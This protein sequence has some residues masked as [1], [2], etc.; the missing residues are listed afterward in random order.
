MNNIGFHLQLKKTN[1]ER[2]SKELFEK[3]YASL[4]G[5]PMPQLKEEILGL[6]ENEFGFVMPDCEQQILG[7]KDI[8]EKLKEIA[9]GCFTAHAEQRVLLEYF[10]EH[11][12]S[13][14]FLQ[15]VT[16]LLKNNRTHLELN[17]F[18]CQITQKKK[19]KC[20][21]IFNFKIA[22]R[23]AIYQTKAR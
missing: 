2:F 1:H 20:Q 8:K 18:K 16:F 13:E 15:I 6:L 19:D 22:V 14:I 3:K 4:R 9:S 23:S 12:D 21:L 10:L 5:M 7:P 11:K 17:C